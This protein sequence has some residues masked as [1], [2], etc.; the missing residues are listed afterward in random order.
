MAGKIPIEVA[1]EAIHAYPTVSETVKGAFL[2][3]AEKL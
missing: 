3:L 1:G 2:Q